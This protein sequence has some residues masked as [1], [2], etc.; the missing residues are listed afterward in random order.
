MA[1]IKNIKLTWYIVCSKQKN[2][3]IYE[4][5]SKQ[6]WITK[7]VSR[8]HHLQVLCTLVPLRAGR[9]SSLSQARAIDG[10]WRFESDTQAHMR[11][12]AQNGLSVKKLNSSELV[13][14][15]IK[16]EQHC[17]RRLRLT[18]SIIYNVSL[19]KISLR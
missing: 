18:I 7:H 15:G 19:L 14:E 9:S 10:R 17:W 16:I 4:I 2:M 3:Y 8:I 6:G 11:G 1:W 5:T 12:C 13:L